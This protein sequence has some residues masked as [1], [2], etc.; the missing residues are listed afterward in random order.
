MITYHNAELFRKKCEEIGKQ[1]IKLSTGL[2][3]FGS[4]FEPSNEIT[5]K[6]LPYFQQA[7]WGVP[8]N[9]ELTSFWE[10]YH[11]KLDKVNENDLSIILRYKKGII[12]DIKL[13]KATEYKNAYYITFIS[14]DEEIGGMMH[15]FIMFFMMHNP[16]VMNNINKINYDYK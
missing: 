10:C 1:I 13:E 2:K 11:D 15:H 7:V 9:Y 12:D 6:T 3:T 5:M 8:M 16:N 4:F 14:P